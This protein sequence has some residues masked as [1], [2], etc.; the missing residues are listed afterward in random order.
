MT[1]REEGLLAAAI[2]LRDD[3]LMRAKMNAHQND[4]EIVV[5]AGNGVWHRFN[6]AIDAASRPTAI[7]KLGSDA[8]G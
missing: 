4:G 2:A 1:L 6:R 8:R 5:E 7:R 3:M